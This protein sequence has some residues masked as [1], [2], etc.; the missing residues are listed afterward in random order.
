MEYMGI[1]SEYP[2]P[3]H[4]T[5]SH[6]SESQAGFYS[7]TSQH[8]SW[9]QGLILQCDY[10]KNTAMGTTDKTHVVY[11]KVLWP[12]CVIFPPAPVGATFLFSFQP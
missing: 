11:Q 5:L 6:R 12:F 2:F 8:I 1:A 3:F 10:C 4:F 9:L 7:V